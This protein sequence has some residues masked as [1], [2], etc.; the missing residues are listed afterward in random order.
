MDGVAAGQL[1]HSADERERG[2]D[3]VLF[4]GE[5]A[6]DQCHRGFCHLHGAIP[7]AA[8]QVEMHDLL[9]HL[10]A[11]GDR[12]PAGARGIEQ[13]PARITVGVPSPG[14]VDEDARI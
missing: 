14:R 9:Y 11:R 6:G 7:L 13:T 5:D 8:A 2:A 10:D 12:H 3:I 4:H 1:T